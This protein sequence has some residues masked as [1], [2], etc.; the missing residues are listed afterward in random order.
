MLTA[1]LVLEGGGVKGIGLVGAIAVLEERG[2]TF[3]R[4]AGTSA[5]AVV[6]ALLA[7]G[8]TATELEQ[9]MRE[10]DYSKLRDENALD[11]L[12][13]LGKAASLLFEQGV[14]RGERIRHWLCDRLGSKHI[15]T[16]GD[17]RLPDPQS[18]LPPDQQY[19]LVVLASDISN[20]E[21]RRLP[22]DYEA[23]GHSG[24]AELVADA[25]RA[26]MSIPFFYRPV[27]I[28][29]VDG[30]KIWL[31]DG[32]MLSN[33]PIAV[34]DRDDDKPPRWPTFGIK[35]SARGD[36]A[37]HVVND[38]RGTFSM[39]GALI[40]T[41]TGFFDRMHIDE[42]SVRARTIFVDTMKVR[43]TDFD[44]DRA[45][46][47]LLY[48]NGRRAAETFLDGGGTRRPW[49]WDDYLRTYRTPT[50]DP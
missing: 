50:D 18:A 37:Q 14:Y 34:F 48:D 31:V 12:G 29:G 21:L 41:M 13:P 3:N 40:S 9:T 2:F 47:R 11:R 32:G 46:Q 44:I 15:S 25:V 1:D 36:A 27:K 39:A 19:R 10:I 17:L 35:L 42:P 26:S 20:G 22:W 8:F 4:I 38:V 23:F 33:F 7:A 30:R 49:N 43:S 5:G 45:T 28:Q 6:G 16:F 24:D